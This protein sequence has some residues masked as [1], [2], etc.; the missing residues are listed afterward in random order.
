M[1]ECSSCDEA[2]KHSF[3]MFKAHILLLCFIYLHIYNFHFFS[4]FSTAF[5]T[6]P[7]IYVD[8]K[9]RI[10]VQ[11]SLK[12]KHLRRVSSVLLQHVR[13]PAQEHC[14][15]YAQHIYSRFQ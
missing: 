6:Y 3:E 11:Y 13:V 10:Q 15:R 7:Y 4:N 2:F 12:A 9:L 8:L 14:Q 1:E 5:L